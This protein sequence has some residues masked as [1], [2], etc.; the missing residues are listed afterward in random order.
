MNGR[1]HYYS[2][3]DTVYFAHGTPAEVYAARAV[4]ATGILMLDMLV[5]GATPLLSQTQAFD[6][7]LLLE[8][9]STPSPDSRALLRLVRNNRIHVRILDTTGLR[10]RTD[11]AERFTLRNAF[12]SALTQPEFHLSAWPELRDQ[13]LRAHVLRCLDHAPADIGKL[14]EQDLAARLEG[15]IELDLSLRQSSAIERT[16]PVAGP[17]LSNRIRTGLMALAIGNPTTLGVTEALMTDP[18]LDVSASGNRRSA[19]YTLLTE[20]T[21]G[22]L[23]D[24]SD[25]A[26][27]ERDVRGIVDGAYNSVVADS[28]G[29]TG[30]FTLCPTD[31]VAQ[32]LIA[33]HTD[34]S[35]AGQL[36]SL[37]KMPGELCGS[38][39]ANSMSY[40]RTSTTWPV[41]VAACS[42]CWVNT[43]VT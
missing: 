22:G 5:G 21:A 19:W 30:A 18:R 4:S 7:A 9:L 24:D 11:H 28:L 1:F 35:A 34:S 23:E 10:E 43:P 37:V 31:D 41:L 17:D 2:A 6:N 27:I 40:C 13:Q 42:M 16:P 3:L 39:G 8:Q 25:L 26:Y 20:M 38:P 15:L 29:A 33:D 14:P 12:C 36:G 32:A